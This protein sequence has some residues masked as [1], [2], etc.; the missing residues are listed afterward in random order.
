M[1]E[2]NEKYDGFLLILI[3]G[4]VLLLVAPLIHAVCLALRALNGEC[5]GVF[6]LTTVH[7]VSFF[8]AN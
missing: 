2:S 3:G 8:Q 5:A 6:A 4:L 1:E 7:I